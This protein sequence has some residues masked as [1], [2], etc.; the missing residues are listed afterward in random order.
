V[1]PLDFVPLLEDTGMIK[2][3]GSW[4]L[5]QA[6]LDTVG[7]QNEGFVNLKINVNVSAVQFLQ[8]EIL[9]QTDNAIAMSGIS[10][11]QLELE[12]TESLLL[13]GLGDT[14]KSLEDLSSMGVSLSIDDF[15]TGYSSLAYIK[16]LPINT[17]KID[18]TFVRDLNTNIDDAAIIDAICALS[19]SLR[20]KVVVEGVETVEQLYYLRG[21]GVSAVQGHL[22]SRPIPARDVLAYLKNKNQMTILAHVG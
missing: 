14:L 13:E 15:G 6:C 19:R 5:E 4:V 17:L 10:P 3:V 8:N 18:R 12:I 21:I 22:F 2:E 20:F 7:W 16:R 1:S 9:R 11:H